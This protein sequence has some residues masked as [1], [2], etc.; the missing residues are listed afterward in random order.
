M[1]VDLH[2]TKMAAISRIDRYI[3]RINN[4]NIALHAQINEHRVQ[5]NE[6]DDV[7]KRL[8]EENIKLFIYQVLFLLFMFFYVFFIP[9]DTYSPIYVYSDNVTP[10]Y[11]SYII[12]LN[13][14]IFW[15]I[16]T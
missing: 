6:Q 14:S 9:V 15:A 1:V 2:Q 7:I 3:E 11:T 16:K 12:N 13:Y 10:N 4:E 5:I 8:E